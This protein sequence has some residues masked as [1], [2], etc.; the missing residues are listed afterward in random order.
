MAKQ[1]EEKS[2]VFNLNVHY[3]YAHAIGYGQK[4]SVVDLVNAEE[5]VVKINE[6]LIN[7]GNDIL[8]KFSCHGIKT[9]LNKETTNYKGEEIAAKDNL[10]LEVDTYSGTV[11]IKYTIPRFVPR[12]YNI[13]NY[14][15]INDDPYVYD[16]RIGYREQI[17]ET[18]Y[19]GDSR[20]G[21]SPQ[22]QWINKYKPADDFGYI[23]ETP[24]RMVLILFKELAYVD[25][26]Q[27]GILK[28][29]TSSFDLN[30]YVVQ[31][32]PEAILEITQLA[33]KARTPLL[34]RDIPLREVQE[35]K[36]GKPQ[37]A[38]SEEVDL[39]SLSLASNVGE[40]VLV[41]VLGGHEDVLV[42]YE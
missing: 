10:T 5:G 11:V 21:T 19:S 40:E 8:V 9:I 6:T 14:Q 28:F 3:H 16:E 2:S 7:S 37:L 29:R 25:N 36:D 34:K 33:D 30:G 39:G 42:H 13:Q 1:A 17:R 12:N 22:F 32:F 38:K 35:E 4:V 26:L 15:H 18:L 20:S 24:P 23:M 27:K 41:E 31:L